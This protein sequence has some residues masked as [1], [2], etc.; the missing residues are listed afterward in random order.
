MP[1]TNTGF[2]FRL[3]EL[4]KS[5]VLGNLCSVGVIPYH[6]ALVTACPYVAIP[7][8]AEAVSPSRIDHSQ[9]VL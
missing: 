4:H 6:G 5:D 2:Y 7:T 9:E 8:T 1:H 3:Q